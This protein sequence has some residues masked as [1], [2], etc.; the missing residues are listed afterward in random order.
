MNNSGHE[1]K[2]KTKDLKTRFFTFLLSDMSLLAQGFRRH[3]WPHR[4]SRSLSRGVPGSLNEAAHN[5]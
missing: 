3:C 5:Q 4:F 2:K 1:F